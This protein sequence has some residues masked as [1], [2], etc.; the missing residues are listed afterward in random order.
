[1]TK[2]WVVE[3]EDNKVLDK[4]TNTHVKEIW[5]DA[6]QNKIKTFQKD[7]LTYRQP[8]KKAQKPI[9]VTRERDD[10]FDDFDE[11]ENDF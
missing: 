3:N 6:Y 5:N 7:K 1:M 2:M 11:K 9:K 4:I 10:D 8:A